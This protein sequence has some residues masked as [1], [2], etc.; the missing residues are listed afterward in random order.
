MHSSKNKLSIALC[1]C[2]IHCNSCA[3]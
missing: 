3:S 1:C 2:D